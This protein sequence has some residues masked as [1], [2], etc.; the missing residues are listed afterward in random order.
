MAAPPSSASPT[1]PHLR[2]D[3]TAKTHRAVAGETKADFEFIARNDGDAEVVVASVL[4]SCR[5]TVANFATTPYRIPPHASALLHAT[6]FFPRAQDAVAQA[7]FVDST[8]GRDVLHVT[9]E[10]PDAKKDPGTSGAPR[11]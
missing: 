3:A 7:V 5:C 2:W 10:L 9:V 1:S 6:V 11:S 4:T 8:A